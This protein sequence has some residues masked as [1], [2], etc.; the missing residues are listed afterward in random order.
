MIQEDNPYNKHDYNV[1][2]KVYFKS[3]NE[4]QTHEIHLNPNL[5]TIIGG[6]SS[7]K[8][9]LL[10]KIASTV[11]KDEI[12]LRKTDDV[13]KVPYEESFLN[14][15]EF[16]VHWKDGRI[17]KSS[18]DNVGGRITYIP[19]MYINSLSE[20][21]DN[22]IFQDKI[23][24][25]LKKNESVKDEFDSLLQSEQDYISK[26]NELSYTLSEKI[27]LLNNLKVEKRKFYDIKVY[28]EEKRKNEDKLEEVLNSTKIP[29]EEVDLINKYKDQI[30][31]SKDELD[32]L[33]M[34]ITESQIVK[35]HLRDI[36][37]ITTQDVN[38]V[39]DSELASILSWTKSEVAEI[40]EKAENK[41]KYIENNFSK[42][43]EKHSNTISTLKG[44]VEE[45]EAKYTNSEKTK[46]IAE[47]KEKIEEQREIIEKVKQFDKDIIEVEE[48]VKGLKV[49]LISNFNTIYN[50]Q[51]QLVKFIEENQNS[52]IKVK[53]YIKFEQ[54]KF[55]NKFINN[56][57]LR[58]NINNKI[59]KS[60]R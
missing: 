34:K 14:N 58:R 35:E 22:E 10:Y 39:S 32:N 40:L 13:W 21:K 51:I 16:E 47:L 44:K 15:I 19:Q 38:N 26:L 36:K 18:E 29:S 55:Q 24:G 30:R 53:P 45:I 56:F 52:Q 57:N 60:I 7:G 59:P 1:I 12:E 5:N 27:E 48:N 42:K 50:K 17:S 6:K 49:D 23:K 11:S 2:D 20:D 41:L 4:F 43:H 54:D 8:S 9:L 33:Q 25:I 28:E 46:I 31:I 3:P 37:L